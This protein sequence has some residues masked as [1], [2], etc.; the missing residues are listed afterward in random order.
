MIKIII[1]KTKYIKQNEKHQL[2]SIGVLRLTNYMNK[3][4]KKSNIK[5]KV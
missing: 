1:I 5:L 4:R 2:K 3:R